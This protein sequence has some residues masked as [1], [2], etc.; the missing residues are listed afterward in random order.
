[1]SDVKLIKCESYDNSEV[2]MRELLSNGLLDWVQPNM[3][4]AIKVNLVT[5]ARPDTATT[6]HPTLVTAL[7]KILK[8]KNCQVVIGDSPGGLYNATFLNAVYSASGMKECEAAGAILNHNFKQ[9]TICFKE[10]KIAKEFLYTAFLDDCDAIINFCKL[11]THGMMGMSAAAKNMFGVIPGTIKPEYHFRYPNHDDFANM[12]V[13]LNEYVKPV[14][15][16]CDG[17]YAMEGNGPTMGK[18]RYVGLIAAAFS[19]H[20]LDLALADIIGLDKTTVPT[21]DAAITRGL[22]PENVSDLLID[23]DI[24]EFK[25]TDFKNIAAKRSVLFKG[26][27]VLGAIVGKFISLCLGSKPKLKQDM[28]VGCGECARICPAKAIDIKNKKAVIDRKACIKCF[29]CQ[30]FCPVGAMQTKRPFIAK[31]LNK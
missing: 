4:I 29:C 19:P 23:G 18:P 7:V 1:M 5:A 28:C 24:A 12:L 31:I 8:E 27:G 2:A 22:I 9:K 11:K 15:S 6:T 3:K 21:L 20:K 30:E 17:I 16:I 25:I 14:L 10:G 13:D 26:K